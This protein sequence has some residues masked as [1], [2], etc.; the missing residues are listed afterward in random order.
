MKMIWEA[1]NSM[2]IIWEAFNSMKIIR[3]AFNS[4]KIGKLQEFVISRFV[5][6]L[7]YIFRMQ[8]CLNILF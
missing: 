7:N 6:T 1:L 4:V 3:E 2:K 8:N 5:Q